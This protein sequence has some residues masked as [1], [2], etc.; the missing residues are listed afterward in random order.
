MNANLIT[1]GWVSVKDRLPNANEGYEVLAIDKYNEYLVGHL[2]NA[3]VPPY[4]IMTIC[5]AEDQLLQNVTHWMPL[6][7]PPRG[8][9]S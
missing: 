6:P 3:N 2:C 9:G 5:E 4:G 1:E 8:G 7:A